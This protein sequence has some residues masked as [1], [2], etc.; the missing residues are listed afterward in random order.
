MLATAI[1]ILL[2][3]A[4]LGAGVAAL[5]YLAVRSST[6]TLA[7]LLAV[8]V[9]TWA[10]R[11]AIDLSVS[12]SDMRVYA[13]DVVSVVLAGVG[14]ARILSDGV[15][16]VARGLVLALFLLLAFHVARGVGEF[17]VQPAVN[18]VRPTL[19]FIFALLYAATVPGGW[20]RRAWKL[21]AA[22]GVLLAA[23]AV[24]YWITEGLGSAKSDVLVNGQLVTSRP[25][26]A[27]G[28]LL[29]L[30]AAILAAVLRWPSRQTSVFAAFGAGAAVL[31]LQH[32]TVW[33]AGALVAL[34]AS[35]WWLVR[36]IHR[37]RSA[38]F[39]ATAAVLL[40]LPLA[41]LGFTRTAPL[42]TSA[43]EVTRSDSSLSERTSGWRAL[44]STHDSPSELATGQPAGA[45]FARIEGG[46]LIARSPHDGFIEA[47]IR[48]GLPGTLCLLS[49][50]LLL[51]FRRSEIGP[52]TGL[53]AGA[54]G[55]LVLTQ[56]VYS[57]PYA[58]D[59]IQGMIAGILVAGLSTA[60]ARV[61]ALVR[62]REHRE[63]SV[64]LRH[65]SSQ[66]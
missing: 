33:V 32:R 45:G 19:Y 63:R 1:P 22:T 36:H 57:I 44:L 37:D 61:P 40:V 12:I 26:N 60:P 16:N 20:D 11:D 3:A 39:A 41:V 53:T 8:W 46:V 29:I 21:L 13:L 54:V 18:E 55:L 14:I 43:K 28:A 48:F 31:L 65:A 30:Q 56:L 34:V 50:G 23:I 42:V 64:V 27:T 58:L 66:S 49:L 15:Q 6:A 35:F 38:V 47:Y 59:A 4:G 25:I 5:S 7:V 10:L 2:A 62:S 9:A 24:P 17:G 51:W 52:A